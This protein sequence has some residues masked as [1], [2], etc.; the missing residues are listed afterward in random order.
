MFRHTAIA[1]LRTGRNAILKAHFMCSIVIVTMLVTFDI[2]QTPVKVS[3]NEHSPPGDAHPS[4][5]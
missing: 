1:P 4:L 5:P 2:A 3:E